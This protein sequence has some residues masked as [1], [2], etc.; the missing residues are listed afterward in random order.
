M[1]EVM[2]CFLSHIKKW[3]TV[4]FFFIELNKLTN[5]VL[6]SLMHKGI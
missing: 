5:L 6:A 4:F 1:Q 3:N 2:F